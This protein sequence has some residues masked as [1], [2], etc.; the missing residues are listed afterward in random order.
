MLIPVVLVAALAGAS[1]TRAEKQV[2]RHLDA[3]A[4][5]YKSVDFE[6]ALNELIK[7]RKIS[8]SPD[9]DAQIAVFTGVV[10][11]AMGKEDD[12][13][14]AF[15]N[16]LQLDANAQ[17]P[18]SVTISPKIQALF[19]DLKKPKKDL[20]MPPPPEA[21]P[22]TP[23][24]E[25]K[26]ETPPAATAPPQTAAQTPAPELKAG[27]KPRLVVLDFTPAG[28]VPPEVAGALTETATAEAAGRGFFEVMGAKEIQ[29]VLGV[30]RQKQLLG[31]GC[32][33][34]DCLNQL[35]GVLGARFAMSGTVAKLGS[36]YQLNLQVL[37]TKK[38]QPL[39]RSTRLA[40]DLESLRAQIPYAVAEASGTPLPPPP[41]RVVPYSLISGGIA[42]LAGAVIVGFDGL[43]QERVVNSEF[44][45]SAS[46]PAVLKTYQQYRSQSSTIAVEKTAS[47]AALA[48]GAG[49]IAV[50]VYLNPPEVVS[51]AGVRLSLA[52]APNGVAFAGVFP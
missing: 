32:D 33:G 43:S 48:A 7:A 39:G 11:A 23:P 3:A 29:T 1:A 9:D 50:G 21:K 46:N 45:A 4:T 13:T 35:S 2:K 49:L 18:T 51:G 30:E 20:P 25:T 52:P 37:D 5:R 14:R 12:A 47:L 22:D 40:K 44:A 17:L 41:S 8:K 28:G 19:D 10:K 26:P 34:T 24:P 38:G 31:G 6:G 15:Q 16:A 42:V 36:A 27:E